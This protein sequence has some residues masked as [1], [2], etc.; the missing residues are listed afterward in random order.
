[1]IAIFD[2]PSEMLYIARKYY[3]QPLE[4]ECCRQLREQIEP[5]TAIEVMRIAHVYDLAQL[6]AATW[7]Y[8]TRNVGAV[9]QCCAASIERDLLV[10]I[11]EQEKLNISEGTLFMVVKK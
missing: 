4:D 2:K 8:I 5:E 9:L 10:S 3:I 11:L 6:L 7:D 1:M